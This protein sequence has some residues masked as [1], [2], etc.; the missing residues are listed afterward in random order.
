MQNVELDMDPTSD[1]EAA[2]E[3]TLC[4]NYKQL[5]RWDCYCMRLSILTNAN[6]DNRKERWR[7]TRT[8]SVLTFEGVC[9]LLS[10]SS[11]LSS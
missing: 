10:A 9:I 2:I 1:D 7:S 11:T 3:Q 4:G 5:L 8:D 6:K